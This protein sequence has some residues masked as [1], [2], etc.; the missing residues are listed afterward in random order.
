MTRSL[1]F[2]SAARR[3]FTNIA[4]RSERAW[5]KAKTREYLDEIEAK[6]RA[7]V[8]NPML[9]HDAGLPREGLRRISAGRDVIFYTFDD[10][11]VAV[12][13]ILHDRMD[14]EALIQ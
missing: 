14:F 3:D 10:H 7:I 9:G 6:F 5:G 2:S 11:E 1:R 13:R 4:A 12:V 8:D